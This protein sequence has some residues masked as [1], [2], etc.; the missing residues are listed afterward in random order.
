MVRSRLAYHI[1]LT[2]FSRDKYYN[3]QIKHTSAFYFNYRYSLELIN[4]AN[5]V[6]LCAYIHYR[7]YDARMKTVGSQFKSCLSL[8][9]ISD[10]ID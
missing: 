4:K 2:K 1:R 10:F 3:I 8:E 7:M 5:N 6:C 9:R